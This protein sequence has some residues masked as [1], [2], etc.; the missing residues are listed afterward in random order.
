MTDVRLLKDYINQSVSIDNNYTYD[1]LLALMYLS[2]SSS[3]NIDVNFYVDSSESIVSD[4]NAK[5]IA[6]G[7]HPLDNSNRFELIEKMLGLVNARI[8]FPIDDL[9]SNS[10]RLLSR[11]CDDAPISLYKIVESTIGSNVYIFKVGDGY[12]CNFIP[13][14]YDQ[15]CA[16]VYTYLHD[17]KIFAD[18]HYGIYD[19]HTNTFSHSKSLY[20]TDM[21]RFQFNSSIYNS[22]NMKCYKFENKSEFDKAKKA[23]DRNEPLFFKLYEDIRVI[24]ENDLQNQ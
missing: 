24:S 2:Y 23:F 14:K 15:S 7:A 5:K 8:V 22:P 19:D 11:Y 10:K 18:S 3:N 20:S 21:H 13:L 16:D 9:V 1:E 4:V 12:M 6:I 17:M